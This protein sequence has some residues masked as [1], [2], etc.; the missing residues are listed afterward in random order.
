MK[1]R[2][3]YKIIENFF[4]DFLEMGFDD[5]DELLKKLLGFEIIERERK[6]KKKKW[7]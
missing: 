4:W 5:Y 7:K 3:M 6:K 1:K 2:D